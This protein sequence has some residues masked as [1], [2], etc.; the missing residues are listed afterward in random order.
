MT[1][2]FAASDEERNEIAGK[3]NLVARKGNEKENVAK[4]FGGRSSIAIEFNHAA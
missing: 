4:T 3:C 1:G 2:F